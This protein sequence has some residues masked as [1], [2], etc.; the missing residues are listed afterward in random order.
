MTSDPQWPDLKRLKKFNGEND[1]R[2]Y[3]ETII[4]YILVVCFQIIPRQVK[5]SYC[6]PIMHFP[7]LC[8]EQQHKQK[9]EFSMAMVLLKLLRVSTTP[10]GAN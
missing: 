3:Y 6:S 2:K 10:A 5:L 9:Q 7:S 8:K 1:A 4:V